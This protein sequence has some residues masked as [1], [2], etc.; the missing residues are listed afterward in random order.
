MEDVND[1]P[2][3]QS[4]A[5]SKFGMSYTLRGQWS[6]RNVVAEFRT[7]TVALSIRH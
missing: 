7:L 4:L 1:A 5:H 6:M 2:V 3:L